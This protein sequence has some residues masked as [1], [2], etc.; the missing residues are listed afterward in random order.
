MPA[1]KDLSGQRFNRLLVIRRDPDKPSKTNGVYFL[2]L[3]DCGNTTSVPSNLLTTGNTQSC[4]CL[5][6]EQRKHELGWD[7]PDV[8]NS[9]QRELYAQK[10]DMGYVRV[11]SEAY[12]ERK[13]ARLQERMQENPEQVREIRRKAGARYYA[14]HPEKVMVSNKRLRDDHPEYASLYAQTHPE[15]NIAR[16]Q[17]RRARLLDAPRN[18]LTARQWMKIK[19]AYNYR[20]VYCGTKPKHLTQDHL[21]P[22]SKGGSHTASNV[23][24]ACKPCNSKKHAGAVLKPIQP[25]LLLLA[26]PR[27]NIK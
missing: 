27:A 17:R 4:G 16:K 5:K 13:K 9:R 10:R 1:F 8:A 18:D 7:H 23:V 14:T 2:C 19:A 21:T 20:C 26:P 6:A 12:R 24:P 11:R 22:L 25:M 15:K 3:C